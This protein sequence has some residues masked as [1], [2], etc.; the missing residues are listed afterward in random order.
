MLRKNLTK[1]HVFSTSRFDFEKKGGFLF[2]SGFD[3]P[4][5][6]QSK[7]RKGIK[8]FSYYFKFSQQIINYCFTIENRA[9]EFLKDFKEVKRASYQEGFD[10]AH[11]ECC[12]E[13]CHPNEVVEYCQ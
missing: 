6:I 13:S 12:N 8:I 5:E 2:P 9:Y 3:S 7:K 4:K 10:N 1:F 11:E